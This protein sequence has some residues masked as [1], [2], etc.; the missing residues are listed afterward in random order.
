MDHNYRKSGI[1]KPLQALLQLL[2]YHSHVQYTYRSTCDPA[3][4]TPS[5][6]SHSLVSRRPYH[7]AG[8]LSLTRPQTGPVDSCFL[9]HTRFRKKCL[10]CSYAHSLTRL[11]AP[12]EALGGWPS[13]TPRQT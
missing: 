7:N 4:T 2:A 12:W 3:L 10:L 13:V 11:N 9:L 5:G 1:K 8:D 6:Q